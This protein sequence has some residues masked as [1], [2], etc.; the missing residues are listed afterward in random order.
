MSKLTLENVYDVESKKYINSDKFFSKTE[1]DIFKVRAEL[2]RA[3]QNKKLMYVCP[4]CFQPVAIKGKPSGKV[5]IHFA[6]IKNE[7]NCPLKSDKGR[8]KSEIEAAKYRGFQESALHKEL[9]FQI[10]YLLK[11]IENISEIQVEKSIKNGEKEWKKPD[12]QAVYK[13]QQ[14]I[15][16]ELQLSTT[17]LSEIIKRE[18]FYHNANIFTIW[19]FHHFDKEGMRFSEK[20]ILYASK[21]HAFIIDQTTIQ[22]SR[23]AKDFL[24]DCYYQ[25]V[26][27][28]NNAIET[29]WQHTL[30]SF[31]DLQFDFE[32]MKLYYYD[33]EKEKGKLYEQL[34][35]SNK[36]SEKCSWHSY[37]QSQMN[38]SELDVIVKGKRS[39]D[40]RFAY[41]KTPGNK[42]I[43]LV[44]GSISEEEIIDTERFYCSL[45]MNLIWFVNLSSFSE[46][47]LIENYA[48]RLKKIQEDNFHRKVA[49]KR[50]ILAKEQEGC[51]FLLS[52]TEEKIDDLII[53]IELKSKEK[54]SLSNKLSALEMFSNQLQAM[55]EQS[56]A[57]I[58]AYIKNQEEILPYSL[59]NWTF[60]REFDSDCEAVEKIESDTKRIK[61]QLRDM[62]SLRT[63]HSVNPELNGL[64]V[65]KEEYITKENRSEIKL[66]PI[67]KQPSLFETYDVL[68]TDR[69]LEWAMRR[70]S[71]YNFLMDITEE[72][73]SLNH[74][75]E[76]SK[77]TLLS[78]KKT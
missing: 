11:Y 63:Y 23:E 7:E 72:L 57:R 71:E 50:D 27:I 65:L 13:K 4:I 31:D 44:H 51:N 17:F 32:L 14:N 5:R 42:V 20:D 25:A 64:R 9:K 8:S 53:G 18:D 39:L 69:E 6:H 1:E 49:L 47:I 52:S 30:I 29:S 22:K 76:I 19:F 37:L 56:V 33:Y 74:D 46:E 68:K 55:H 60:Q 15:V 34:L 12:V 73:K 26:C 43:E 2:E 70:K 41:I 75:L 66:T 48:I 40:S 3:Y 36:L 28:K 45:H 35:V 10:A 24:I 77:S 67:S 78:A 58:R 21:N 62:Q 16:F 38:K 61:E 59:K 54:G